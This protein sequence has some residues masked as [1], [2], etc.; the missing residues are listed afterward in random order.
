MDTIRDNRWLRRGVLSARNCP[1]RS[2][3]GIRAG[4]ESEEGQILY[5]HEFQDLNLLRDNVSH[6]SEL[7]E[8]LESVYLMSHRISL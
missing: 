8:V 1:R 4:V 7:K 3:G 2:K 5:N 6:F